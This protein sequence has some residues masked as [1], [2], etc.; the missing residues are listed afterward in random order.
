M[1]YCRHQ[2]ACFRTNSLAIK[3]ICAPKWQDLVYEVKITY[4]EEGVGRF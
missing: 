3:A 4:C 1:Q 2:L